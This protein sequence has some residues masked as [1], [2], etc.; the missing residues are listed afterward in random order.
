MPTRCG[1]QLQPLVACLQD[2]FCW[3][4]ARATI[5]QADAGGGT[6][7]MDAFCWLSCTAMPAAQATVMKG[8]TTTTQTAGGP[9]LQRSGWQTCLAGLKSYVGLTLGSC[10]SGP[11]SAP[12]QLSQTASSVQVGHPEAAAHPRQCRLS[13]LQWH[14]LQRKHAWHYLS[15]GSCVLAEPVS[16]GLQT[17]SEH[18]AAAACLAEKP[19]SLATLKY[20]F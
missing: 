12:F 11:L 18:V 14:V 1:P 9:I 7:E 3:R 2:S 17:C 4:C 15:G 20:I 6:G 8:G 13:R 19:H 10:K 16:V 5:A